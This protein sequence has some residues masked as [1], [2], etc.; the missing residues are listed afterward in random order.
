MNK[1]FLSS[2]L[3]LCMFSLHG[4]SW[5]EL[6]DQAVSLYEKGEFSTALPQAER[7]LALA[8]QE[9]G[10][11]HENYGESSLILAE[12]YN[13]LGQYDKALPLFVTAVDV[14]EKTAGK[15]NAQY[16]YAIS[17]LAGVYHSMGAYD[18]ALPLLLTAVENAER[19]LGKDNPEYGSRLN[20]LANLYHFMGAYDK[21]LPMFI[22]SVENAEMTLGK[23]NPEYGSRL[24]GLASLHYRMGAYDKSLALFIESIANAEKH[25]GKR[26]PEYI[27]RLGNLATLYERMGAYDKALSLLTEA[28]ETTASTQGKDHP[29][30]GR[31]LNILVV[32]YYGMGEFEQAIVACLESLANAEINLGKDHSEYGVRLNNLAQ[33]YLAIGQFDKALPLNLQSLENAERSVGRQHSEFGTRLNNLAALYEG[34]GEYEKALPLYLESVENTINSLGKHHQLYGN[35]LINLAYLYRKMGAYDLALPLYFEALENVE[36]ALGKEHASY[37]AYLSSLALLYNNLGNHDKALPLLQE[38]AAV[39]ANALGMEHPKYEAML[40]Y[41]SMAYTAVGDYAAALHPADSALQLMRHLLTRSVKFSSERDLAAYLKRE[42]ANLAHIPSWLH[43]GLFPDYLNEM[44]CDDILFQKGFLL[45]AAAR[46]RRL[47][48][49][50]QEADSLSS[51]L[52]SYY[53]QLSRAY[54]KPPSK[55][56]GVAELEEKVDA[57]EAVL[58]RTVAGYAEALQQVRWREVQGV[59]AADELAIEFIRFPV[60]FPK[61]TDSVYYGALLIRPGYDTPRYVPLFAESALRQLLASNVVRKSA[62]ANELY[63]WVNQGQL[64]PD[65]LRA[66]LY[67]LVWKNIEQ[68]GLDGVSTIYYAPSGVLH[69]LNLGAIALDENTVLANRFRLI[70]LNSTRQLVLPTDFSPASKDAVLIGGVEYNLAVNTTAA[71]DQPAVN[72]GSR[73]IESFWSE[74]GDSR[75]AGWKTLRWTG[76]EVDRIA[77]LLHKHAYASQKFTGRAASE[78]AFKQLGRDKPSPRILHIATHGFFFPDPVT[79]FPEVVEAR[80]RAFKWSEHPMIRSGLIMAGANYAWEHGQPPSPDQEDGVLTAYEISQM[81][82]SN[83]ELVVLSACE[84]GLGDLQGNEGVYGLQRAFRIAGAKYLIM[85]LWQVPDQQTMEFMSTFYQLWLDEGMSIPDAFHKTQEAMRQ[86]FVNPYAWAG[87]VLIE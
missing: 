80:Q 62:Y 57:L 9:Y 20:S 11:S 55:R 81:N 47:S 70:A 79:V 2:L 44:V 10:S 40:N 72:A 45:H 16:G 68:T 36:K 69:R 51:Q 58:S 74:E 24:N 13:Q 7:A 77:T 6:R 14:V 35:R 64:P 3:L 38:A 25:L 22:A 34:M 82:L 87:F 42:S 65:S 50:T 4:Q 27:S 23:D 12:L 5:Q 76:V 59:L 56:T 19:W 32:L 75:S 33:L 53:V 63:G 43:S 18:K 85:S 48:T 30:Y 78:E 26:H 66:S 1:A 54:A 49:T 86:L 71:D 31:L 17:G 41:L 21:A 39:T 83:T 73:S 60:L 61:N 37:G 29:D 46:L 67:D 28:L 8:E 52:R 15:E 84:T